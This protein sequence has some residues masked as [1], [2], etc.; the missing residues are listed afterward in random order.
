MTHTIMPLTAPLPADKIDLT[1]KSVGGERL[2]PLSL[3]CM[4]GFNSPHNCFRVWG[5][6]EGGAGFSFNFVRRGGGLVRRAIYPVQS[7]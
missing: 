2:K 1:T 7:F 4:G 5:E 3:I 6:R